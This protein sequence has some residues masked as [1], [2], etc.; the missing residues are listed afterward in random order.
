MMVQLGVSSSLI[1]SARRQQGLIH[2]YRTLCTQGKCSSC[3]LGGI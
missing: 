2:I 3:P 1:N